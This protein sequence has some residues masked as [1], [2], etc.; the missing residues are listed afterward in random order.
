MSNRF[1]PL[2]AEARR[3]H[4]R[5]MSATLLS[6]IDNGNWRMHRESRVA[7]GHTRLIHDGLIEVAI[8]VDHVARWC[9]VYS[10]RAEA[11]ETSERQRQ[12]FERA[13]WQ[14]R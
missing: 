14:G 10:D 12:T 7:E 4:D 9:C 3:A 5:R 8:E 11:L 13:G 2:P 1:V 6:E